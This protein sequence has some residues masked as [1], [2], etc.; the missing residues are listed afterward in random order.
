M[1]NNPAGIGGFAP[2]QS[3]NPNG[4]PQSAS[5]A[6]LYM[7]RYFREAADLLVQIMRT[8]GKEDVVRLAAIK[9]VL[10]RGLGKAPQA[11]ALDLTM[12]K[13]LVD[14]TPDELR[15]FRA[16]YVA[17]ATAAPA[18]I[19]AVLAQE[20]ADAEPQLE[21]DGA[22][23]SAPAAPH[24]TA[25]ASDVHAEGGTEERPASRRLRRINLLGDKL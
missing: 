2:G 18:A 21:L 15:E 3:G 6:Q 12:S 10:D 16:R 20:E 23:Q 14:M 13:Q 4:R 8:G 1:S 9:E 7:L 25:A 17:A 5:T 11:I 19:D 24:A 22:E